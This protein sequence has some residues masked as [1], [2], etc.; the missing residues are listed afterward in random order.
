M[1][2]NVRS[3]ANAV[4]RMKCI[5][6]N[7]SILKIKKDLKSITNILPMTLEK[8]GKPYLKL[9]IENEIRNY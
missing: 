1:Y 4:L 7:L 9:I 3:A 8:E 6:G 5:T 2:Q